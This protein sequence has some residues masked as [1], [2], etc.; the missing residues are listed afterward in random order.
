MASGPADSSSGSTPPLEGPTGFA[1]A[2]HELLVRIGQGSY[3]EV[4]L[5]RNVFGIHRAVKVVYR[6]NFK[7]NRPFQREY[8]GIRRFEPISRSHEGFVDILQVGQDQALSY[9]YYVMELGDDGHS[10][11]EKGSHGYV[12]RTLTHELQ[13]GP[14]PLEECIRIGLSLSSALHQ[15]HSQGLVH[16]DVKPS[17]IIFVGGAPKLADIGLVAEVNEARSYVG[18]EGFI[19]PEGPG[20]EQA[21]VYSLGKVLYEIST[22]RDRM[23]F[24]ALP[25]NLHEH[26]DSARLLELDEILRRAC[27]SDSLKRY[28]SAW[29]LHADLLL[30]DHGG[31]VKR[32]RTL[33]RRLKR[34]KRIGS[35]T[36]VLLLVLGILTVPI[37][38]EWRAA[39]QEQ[40]RQVA[41]R[42]AQG[43]QLM[44]QGDMA[45]ALVAYVEALRLDQG[46]PD[47]NA[48]HRL[49]IGS[50]L[51]QCPRIIGQWEVDH[52]PLTEAWLT[53]D[54]T[55]ILAVGQAGGACL[56]NLDDDAPRPLA[57]GSKLSRI[58][59]AHRN[60]WLATAHQ[61]RAATIWDAKNWTKLLDLPHPAHVNAL[62]FNPDDSL[63]ATAADDSKVRIW[64]TRSGALQHEWEAHTQLVTHVRFSPDGRFLASASWDDT[65]R[66]WD[67]TTGLPVGSPLRHSS[68]VGYVSF[69]PGGDRLVTAGFDHV[70]RVWEVPL[71]RQSLSDLVHD[72]AVKSAEFSPDG[73]WIV[74]ASLDG[75]VRIWEAQTGRPTTRNPILRHSNRVNHAAFNKDSQRVLTTSLDGTVTLWDLAATNAH[76]IETIE[77]AVFSDDGR[78]Y[79]MRNESATQVFVATTRIPYGPPIALNSPAS[80][81]RLDRYGRLLLVKTE[82]ESTSLAPSVV[83]MFEVESN[84]LLKTLRWKPSLAAPSCSSS[85]DGQWFGIAVSNLVEVCQF[86]GEANLRLLHEQTVQLLRFNRDG[87]F[88]ATAA[89]HELRVFELPSG[90]LIFGPFVFAAQISC[91]EFSRS[92]RYLAAACQDNQFTSHSARVLDLKTGREIGKP[93]QHR[94]GIHSLQ[95]SPDSRRI[96]TAGEDFVAQV[97]DVA[98]GAAVTPP[99]RHRHQVFAAAF[100]LDG[101]WV[102]TTGADKT[103]RIWDAKTGDPLAPPLPLS[104]MGTSIVFLDDHPRILIGGSKGAFWIWD[105]T[106]TGKSPEDLTSLANSITGALTP[107]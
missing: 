51:Q 72:D 85:P 43:V 17:N 8:D 32:L 30:L 58:A 36:A 45:A 87:R 29:A 95:F 86:Q 24:P 37:Y 2:D 73:R 20:T 84:R 54:E 28:P 25:V 57:L 93:L 82:P 26:P 81:V 78:R 104:E 97:W 18:T 101:L 66:I 49:R 98:T 47:K 94:D 74:T 63:L 19:P 52:H 6:N 50:V 27:E 16:R 88:L 103:V 70:V 68:W 4:W 100:S 79:A 13:R 42:I 96:V 105:L 22:G 56:L 46:N 7:D 83:E 99:L 33:E 15:L 9:F 34:V 90:G 64:D 69:S 11:P 35:L 80:E 75:T 31:S 10:E 14:L 61:A 23:D 44:G 21:D 53:P 106:P 1:V 59:F 92:G 102:A 40:E 12:P 71:G 41:T 67:A 65:A 89:D 38:R 48:T 77:G 91:V 39:I 3:G 5:A 62:D 76:R 60:M 107:D 55:A